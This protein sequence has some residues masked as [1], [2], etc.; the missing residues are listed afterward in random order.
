MV[1]MTWH[2]VRTWEEVLLMQGQ[3][4]TPVITPA[5]RRVLQR[6]VRDCRTAAGKP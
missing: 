5:Q 1:E 4:W 6:V 3:P 2:G